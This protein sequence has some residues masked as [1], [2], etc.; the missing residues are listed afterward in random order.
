MLHLLEVKGKA[1]ECF[2]DQEVIVWHT[3]DPDTSAQYLA[4]FHVSDK[5]CQVVPARYLAGAAGC[6]EDLWHKRQVDLEEEIRLAGH[7]CLLLKF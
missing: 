5:A 1:E 6:A 2:R 4:V 3:E 7:E